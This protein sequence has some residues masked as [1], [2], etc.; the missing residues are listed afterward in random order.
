MLC[1]GSLGFRRKGDK[2]TRV[3]DQGRTRS[4]HE[5]LRLQGST[6]GTTNSLAVLPAIWDWSG[7]L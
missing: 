7:A 6:Q 1:A 3:S 5:S 4:P 2:M